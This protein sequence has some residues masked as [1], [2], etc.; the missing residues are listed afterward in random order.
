[1]NDSILITL[2]VVISL[3]ILYF[4]YVLISTFV[5]N[6]KLFLVRG[7]DPD[8]PC[9]LRLSDY[10]ELNREPIKIGYYG[11][12]IQGYLYTQKGKKDEKGFIILSHGF[13]GTHIQYLADIYLLTSLGYQVLAFDQYGVGDSE[14]RNQVSLAN[15][16]YVLENVIRY[17]LKNNI[18]NNQD[19]ILYGHSWGA[20]CSLCA[21]KK[22]PEVKKAILRSGFVSPTKTVLSLLKDSK[23]GFY[24]SIRPLYPLCY[25]LLFGLRN[26]RKTK[27]VKKNKTEILAIHSMDDKVVKY[28][29]SIAKSLSKRKDNHIR[30]FVTEK[31]EHNS[32]IAKE[33][34]DNYIKSISEYQKI[35]SAEGEDKNRKIEEFI[36]SLNRRTMYPYNEEVRK[37]IEDFLA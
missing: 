8:N 26:T 28:K 15:G 25:V 6:K 22:Y 37:E 20:Y 34:L 18:H 10:P 29:D 4:V 3:L 9:Y 30:I 33:G 12:K 17:V 2:I 5:I 21:L 14:G 24:Y 7:V 16:S 36:A 11:E 32:L 19:I 1:M 27:L 35:L 23:K 13:F 31:G